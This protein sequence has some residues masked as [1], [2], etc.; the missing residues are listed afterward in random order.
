MN[1]LNAIHKEVEG[2]R[3]GVVRTGD[4]EAGKGNKLGDSKQRF[5]K[6][7]RMIKRYV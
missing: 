1:F 3:E 7:Y 4:G 6:K 2:G 5:K